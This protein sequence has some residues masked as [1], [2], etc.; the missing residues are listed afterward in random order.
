MLKSDDVTRCEEITMEIT[1]KKLWRYDK[2]KK[3]K[4][5]IFQV[6][7]L[8]KNHLSLIMSF[9]HSVHLFVHLLFHLAVHC[10]SICRSSCRSSCLST[11]LSTCISTFCSLVCHLSHHLFV[12]LSALAVC[13]S[14]R[15]P[16]CLR[17]CPAIFPPICL[18][19]CL[20]LC[21]SVFS[22]L[23]SL[24]CFFQYIF[25]KLSFP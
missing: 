11:C 13:L 14:L 4:L 2:E 1:I 16:V 8:Y 22:P 3:I 10:L 15:S 23:C 7:K 20:L 6:L 19:V 21:S 24:A 5:Y 12:H 25:S 18:L 9:P 17:M